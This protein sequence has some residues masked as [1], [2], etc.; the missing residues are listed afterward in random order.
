[1]SRYIEY[2]VEI[3]TTSYELITASSPEEA[4]QLAESYAN[5]GRETPRVRAVTATPAGRQRP[6]SPR[7]E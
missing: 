3:A 1:V 2:V 6:S 5:A 4:M 7:K